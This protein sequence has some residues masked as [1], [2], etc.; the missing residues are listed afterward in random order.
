M[1]LLN[2]PPV[3][4][5]KTFPQVQQPRTSLLV[6]D[7]GTTNHMIPDK[8]AF[9]SYRPCSGQRV[10]M[11]NNSFAPI[12][13]TRSAIISLNKKKILIHDCLHVLALWNPLY[14]LRAHQH[15][16]NGCGF[17]G[18]YVMGMYLFFPSFIL[19]V[20]MAVDCHLSYEP[21]GRSATLSS[22]NYV[23]PMST[24]S[25]ST[26]KAPPLAPA[27]TKPDDHDS[28]TPTFANHW[29]KKP[30]MAPPPVF[31]LS[32]IPPLPSQSSYKTWTGTSSYV[33]STS[34]NL[35]SLP[36]LVKTCCHGVQLVG[37]LLI[38]PLVR[39]SNPSGARVQ[40]IGSC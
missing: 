33:V 32:M 37:G 3:H 19:K 18:L 4:S 38:E 28:V 9:I 12:L 20:D 29:P 36:V 21:L 25:A 16:Q 11:G 35:Q 13:G 15:H 1:A 22:L 23:Q 26:T 24:I 2:N 31:D 39:G 5:I 27:Q 8:S 7:T 40:W 14:S 17:L 34:Q 10:H 6:A 30:P